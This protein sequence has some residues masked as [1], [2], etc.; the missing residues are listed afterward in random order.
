MAYLHVLSQ[1]PGCPKYTGDRITSCTLLQILPIDNNDILE[2]AQFVVDF[3]QVHFN[4]NK[5]LYINFQKH[6]SIFR[7]AM[8]SKIDGGGHV[9]WYV[10]PTGVCSTTNNYL[11]MDNRYSGLIFQHALANIL[12]VSQRFIKSLCQPTKPYG[13]VG[14]FPNRQ[15]WNKEAYDY[16]DYFIHQWKE[17]IGKPIANIYVREIT[18]MTTRYDNDDSVFLPY[19]TS[20]HQ[21]YAQW[22]FQRGSIFTKKH[23]GMTSYTTWAE[24]KPRPFYAAWYEG[25]TRLDCLS[26]TAFWWRRSG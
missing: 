9:Q 8:L 20:N 5:S 24:Y 25:S 10:L 1:L 6:A 21:Y 22:C 19:H 26:C 12:N 11:S 14:Q 18:G 3:W 2:A 16:I 4:A 15:K 17:D 23:L 13:H 7:K